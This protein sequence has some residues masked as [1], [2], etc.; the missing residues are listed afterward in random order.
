MAVVEAKPCI[1]VVAPASSSLLVPLLLGLL[2]VMRVVGFVCRASS[3]SLVVVSF[4]FALS[5]LLVVVVVFVVVAV[6][7][8]VVGIAA[9]KSLQVTV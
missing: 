6:G 8:V 5:S 7:V 4:G 3:A 9:V 2:S 1:V